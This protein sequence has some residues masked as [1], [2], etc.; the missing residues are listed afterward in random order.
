MQ[1]LPWRDIAG[2]ASP[3]S[4]LAAR[5]NRP[6]KTILFDMDGVLADVSMSYRVAVVET[7]KQYGI[8]VTQDDIVAAKSTGEMNNDW[9]LTHYLVTNGLSKQKSLADSVTLDEIIRKFQAIYQGTNTTPGLR[10]KESLLVSIGLMEELK[11]RC[12]KGLAVVTGRPRDEAMYFLKLHNITHLFDCVVTMDD[13]PDKPDPAPVLLALKQLKA[14]PEEAM[15]IGDTP[16]DVI[17][18]TR[19]GVQGFG[20]LT[21]S[22]TAVMMSEVYSSFG[23]TNHVPKMVEPLMSK[24]ATAVLLPGLSELLDLVPPVS[25]ISGTKNTTTTTTNSINSRSI[26]S[27]ST[28]PPL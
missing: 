25:S 15:M 6:I 27:L 12:S 9:V 24:G 13:A 19:A 20:V 21:P 28:P 3:K 10:D 26:T 8:E 7:A 16:S 22:A 11:R 5:N 17:A 23:A 4:W 14:I 18:A 2:T 1:V